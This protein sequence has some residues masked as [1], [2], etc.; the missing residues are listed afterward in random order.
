M[1][2]GLIPFRVKIDAPPLYIKILPYIRNI[3]QYFGYDFYD[4]PTKDEIESITYTPLSDEEAYEKF[5][6]MNRIL[7][8]YK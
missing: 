3:A 7:N 8:P 1:I 2:P 4:F 5:L 6:E